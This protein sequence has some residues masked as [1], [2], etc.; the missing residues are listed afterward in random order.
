MS[1]ICI[2]QRRSRD[3]TECEHVLRRG[4]ASDGYPVNWPQDPHRFLSPSD[5]MEAWV[6]TEA[7]TGTGTGT[8]IVGHL[9][10]SEGQTER[11][12]LADMGHHIDD[13]VAGVSRFFVRPDARGAGVGAALLATASREAAA[14]GRELMLSVV[15]TGDTSAVA[16]YEHLGWRLIASL[17][18]DWATNGAPPFVMHYYAAPK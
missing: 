4:H 12:E 13:A 14:R 15:D 2:R 16:I 11:R 17:P 3:F 5:E 7:D 1:S 8:A 10:L 9:V 18:L 6:A